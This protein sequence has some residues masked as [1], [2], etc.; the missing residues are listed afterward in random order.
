MVDPRP[1]DTAPAEA[2]TW[3]G[4]AA[5]DAAPEEVPAEQVTLPEDAPEYP[6]DGLHVMLAFGFALPCAVKVIAND[7][8]LLRS[9]RKKAAHAAATSLDCPTITLSRIGAS[10]LR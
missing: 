7:W 5:D 1:V 8:E 10:T 9:V 4:V 6:P 3:P 2:P